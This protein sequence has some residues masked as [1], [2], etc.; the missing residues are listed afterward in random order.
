MLQDREGI[1]EPCANC[2]QKT[3][4]FSSV[5]LYSGERICKACFRKIPKS[6]RQYRYLDYRLFMEGY[7]HADHVLE[8][9]YPAFRVT[10]QYGRMAIDEHHGWVYLGDATDFAKDGKLKYP[11]S[12]LYDCLDLSEVDI[13]VE[14][15]TVH[16][17]TKT[18]EC[19]V[20]FSAVFQAGEIRIEETLK[21]HARGNILAVSDGRHASFAEPVDLAA[22]RNVYNQMV[23]HV[24][25]AAQEAEMT[26]QKKQQD[27][28]WKAAAMA[29]M[30]REIRT[31]MEKEMEAE[32]LARS[33]MQK[34]DEAKSLF[35]LGQEYDLQQLKRQRALLL[36]TFHPDN[37]QVDSAAY[38]QK[39]NDAYQI[40]ANELAKE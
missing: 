38:A 34:L 37:G 30:E 25:S 35:M 32:R 24:V 22:F 23:A 31:R 40:L 19:S 5:K 13:R 16:A 1:M 14:P 12:D 36:K 28:A 20:L 26:M 2:K 3:G 17:G 6:F 21:R 15:G 27:D 18:V 33:R 7:E 9:V 4:L 10:A 11:S 8:H 39:I 29:Q